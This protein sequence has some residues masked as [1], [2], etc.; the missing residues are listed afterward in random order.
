MAP[1]TSWS[2][3]LRAS[4]RE[5]VRRATASAGKSSFT[6]PRRARRDARLLEDNEHVAFGDRL[7]LFALISATL[8]SSSASTGI[9]IFIDSRM[10]TVSPSETSSPTLTSTFQTVPVM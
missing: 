2:S 8:P 5:M 6:F 9:S 1:R 7:A 4:G 3:A 10:T